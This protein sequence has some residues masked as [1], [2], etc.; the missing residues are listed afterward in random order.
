MKRLSMIVTIALT[1][2]PLMNVSIKRP[3]QIAEPLNQG[4]KPRGPKV[5]FS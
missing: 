4:V 2:T 5:E 3:M 1:L